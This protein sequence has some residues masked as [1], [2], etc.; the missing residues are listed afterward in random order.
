[1]KKLFLPLLCTLLLFAGCTKVK[2]EYYHNGK[3]KS[4]THYRFG[5]E[6]G[7]TTY[8]HHW[9]PTKTMEVEMKRGKRNGNFIKRFFDGTTEMVAYYKDDLLEGVEKQYYLNGNISTEIHYIKGVKNGTATTWFSNGI[10]RESGSFVNDM[11]DGEWV[12]YDE[13]GMLVGEGSFVN[14]NGKRTSYDYI[15]RIQCETNFVNNKK[16]G[17]E[18]FYLPSGEIEKTI[19][20]KEDRIIEINGVPIDSL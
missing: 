9:Y 18:T 16:D 11:F 15:G 17:L 6:T 14:G 13:R 8:Y 20:F 3:L 19:L 4:E 2:R 5:K 1:M 10:I 12:N 7:T